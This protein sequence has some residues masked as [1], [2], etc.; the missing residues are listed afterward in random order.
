M[1]SRPFGFEGGY[2]FD[3]EQI[4]LLTD[5][6]PGY[7]IKMSLDVINAMTFRTVIDP[8][9]LPVLVLYEGKGV[10]PTLGTTTIDP[11]F[12]CTTVEDYRILLTNLYEQKHL[13]VALIVVHAACC[14]LF[15]L[16]RIAP[17]TD[18][19]SLA[20]RAYESILIDHTSIVADS[21]TDVLSEII[22]DM[23]DNDDDSLSGGFDFL[24]QF[25]F[26]PN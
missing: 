22:H 15:I 1:T 24:D 2:Q 16:E 9:S 25:P 3:P 6:K 20:Q 5:G 19:D 11:P 18:V 7:V 13:M 21:L 17:M 23:Q 12:V 8:L 4:Q 14:H 10:L 26:S